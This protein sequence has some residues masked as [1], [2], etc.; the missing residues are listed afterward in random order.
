MPITMARMKA[1]GHSRP[2]GTCARMSTK[3]LRLWR[4]KLPWTV[5]LS[6]RAS[7]NRR[8]RRDIIVDSRAWHLQMQ[9]QRKTWE[10][11]W[12]PG[13]VLTRHRCSSLCEQV[14][15]IMPPSKRVP[16]E[17]QLINCSSE[18]A[19]KK[20]KKTTMTRTRRCSS[21]LTAWV[22]C[23]NL[24]S[25]TLWRKFLSWFPLKNLSP[26]RR[27]KTKLKRKWARMRMR[28]MTR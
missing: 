10:G 1:A 4:E 7:H 6:A 26:N 28:V 9:A 11:L 17:S 14:F 3:M 20:R 22:A 12:Q 16:A 5:L 15:I 21:K 18:V 25:T 27:T 23:R 13:V 19:V 24:W 8:S 2:R